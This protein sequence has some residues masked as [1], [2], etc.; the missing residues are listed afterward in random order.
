MSDA[1][2]VAAID[3]HPIFLE[4]LDRVLRRLKEV[5]LVAK[6]A[7]G[8]DA[9]RIASEFL[10]DIMLLDISMPGDGIEAAHAITKSQPSVKIIMLT[11]SDDHER[12]AKAIEKGAHG[13]LLKGAVAAEIMQAI[14][15]VH[16]GQPYITPAIAARFLMQKVRG[17]SQSPGEQN[18]KLNDRERQILE[19]V[20]DGLSNQEIAEKLNLAQPTIK[21]YLS[22][23][24]DKLNVRSRTQAIAV[25]N[26]K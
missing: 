17:Q 2:R 25:W 23:I 18:A 20:T 9:C 12:V 14:K 26:R 16:A 15:L 24:F 7:S 6:G 3:D 13:Y 11:A 4:G 8:A 5:T 10:P 1:I 19:L 22:R 21:N